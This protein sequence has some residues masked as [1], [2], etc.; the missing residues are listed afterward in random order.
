MLQ[1]SFMEVEI[2]NSAFL[3]TSSAACKPS[4]LADE[5]NIHTVL[6]HLKQVTKSAIDSETMTVA[7]GSKDS[8]GVLTFSRTVVAFTGGNSTISSPHL[9]GGWRTRM[10]S[11]AGTSPVQTA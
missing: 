8:S 10:Q 6:A 11:E 2:S 5:A 7:F 4:L 1:I 9:Q 3:R